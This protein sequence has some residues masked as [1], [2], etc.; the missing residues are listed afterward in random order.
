MMP[1]KKEKSIQYVYSGADLL[2]YQVCF[3]QIFVS[4]K[5]L[6]LPVR[7]G[8]TFCTR[9]LAMHVL[10]HFSSAPC[11]SV[12]LSSGMFFLSYDRWPR[13]FVF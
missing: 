2:D 11:N 9:A 3:R 6:F 10:D 4:N 7:T 12:L 8:R 5:A 1:I 13:T